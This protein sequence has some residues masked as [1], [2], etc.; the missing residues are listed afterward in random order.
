MII[1]S[2][3]P[4]LECYL[5]HNHFPVRPRKLRDILINALRALVKINLRCWL[6]KLYA[7]HGKYVSRSGIGPLR[8]EARQVTLHEKT[9]PRSR[10]MVNGACREQFGGDLREEKRVPARIGAIVSI[11]EARETR[12]GVAKVLCVCVCE[13]GTEVQP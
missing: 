6:H 3:L 2:S 7:K 11:C 4:A 1:L 5:V 13:G 10:T 8:R 12:I 9:V